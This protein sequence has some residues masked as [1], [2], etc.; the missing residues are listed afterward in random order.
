MAY[1]KVVDSTAL[2]ASLTAIADAIRAKAGTSD[3]MT[4]AGM[5]EA[6]AAIEAGGGGIA[7]GSYVFA[8]TNSY[9]SR[10]LRVEHGLGQVPT[11][12]IH[13]LKTADNTT[14]S[15]KYKAAY[16]YAFEGGAYAIQAPNKYSGLEMKT[17][18]ES[19]S[20]S[21][22]NSPTETDFELFGNYIGLYGIDGNEGDEVLWF[23][24]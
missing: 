4:L 12:M 7:T 10:S 23:V 2:D 22:A 1:D 24:W 11:Q 6:I 5:A 9:F 19:S 20:F 17:A 8:E 15:G 14:V 3:A 16:V 21:R 13:L 18:D